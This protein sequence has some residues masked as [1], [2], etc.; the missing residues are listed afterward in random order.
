[1]AWRETASVYT[2][3]L[4]KYYISLQASLKKNC[5]LCFLQGR[6]P[7]LLD[8]IRS[9]K[10]DRINIYWYSY[11][12]LNIVS[13]HDWTYDKKKIACTRDGFSLGEEWRLEGTNKCFRRNFLLNYMKIFCNDCPYYLYFIDKIV[14]AWHS[15]LW[16]SEIILSIW[17]DLFKNLSW[18]HN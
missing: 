7:L 2:F 6:F 5:F 15:E 16:S 11:L 9:S 14:Y 3:Y 4:K 12:H 13:H 1:M 17:Y 10:S 18:L 8:N